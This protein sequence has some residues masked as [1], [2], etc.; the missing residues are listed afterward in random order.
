MLPHVNTEEG[1]M[2]SYINMISDH[3]MTNRRTVL[4]RTGSWLGVVTMSRRLDEVF[5][6]SQP[7][8]EP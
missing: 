4:R 2:R 6:V 3:D 5:R 8:P 1:N 7:Q